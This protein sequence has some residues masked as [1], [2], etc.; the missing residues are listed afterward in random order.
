MLRV[1]RGEDLELVGR[2]LG[3]TAAALNG[4]RDGF[5]AAG[6]ASLKTRPEDDRDRELR[7]M[8]EKIG[9]IAMTN[10]LLEA[11]IERLEGGAPFRLRRSRRWAGPSPPP[12]SAPAA[13]LGCA[14][15]GA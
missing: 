11:K 5:P 13:R 14:G 12:R 10:E 1:L 4:W 3:I 15:C 8:R 7:A 2:E 9:E 6:A